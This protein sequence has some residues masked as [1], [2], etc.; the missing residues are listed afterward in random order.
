MQKAEF[1]KEYW[2]REELNKRRSPL[3]PVVKQYV[4]PKINEI[5]KVIPL[6]QNIRLLDV[7]AGNGFFSYWFDQICQ[8]TAIDYSQK[9]IELNPIKNKYVMNA[10]SLEFDDNSFDVVFCHAFLHHIDN[11]QGVL[12]EMKRVSKKYVVIMEPNRNN[13]LMFLFSLIVKEERLALKFSLKYLKRQINKSGLKI[14]SAFSYGLIVPNKCPTFL[15][16][17][18]KRFNKRFYWGMT[19]VIIA[20]K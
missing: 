13:P 5:Q 14:L 15:L 7:G 16:P 2:E 11:M 20:E 12:K 4:L 6:N 1:Q 3:N 8:T 18:V 10:K 9:M 17:L 19:N